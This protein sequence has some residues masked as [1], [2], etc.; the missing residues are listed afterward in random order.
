MFKLF[1]SICLLVGVLATLQV[2]SP[3]CAASRF[4]K[5]IE[6]TLSNFGDIPYGQ[7]LIGQIYLP[8]KIKLCTL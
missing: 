5:P 1:V 6:Y 2:Y 7:T 3:T 4:D 8:S